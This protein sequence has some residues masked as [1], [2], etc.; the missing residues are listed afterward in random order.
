MATGFLA[1]INEEDEKNFDAK[2][3]YLGQLNFKTGS[4]N[5]CECPEYEYFPKSGVTD[6]DYCGHS[7]EDHRRDAVSPH[8]AA[9]WTAPKG[10]GKK[11]KLVKK[12][13]KSITPE[14][15]SYI[16][17][18]G[19]LRALLLDKNQLEALPSK[20]FSR[21]LWTLRELS[22]A[23]NQL[24]TIPK[25]LCHLPLLQTLTV[26]YNKLTALPSSIGK[27]ENLQYLYLNGNLLEEVP[28]E[29]SQLRK[30]KKLHLQNNR[31]RAVPVEIGSLAMLTEFLLFDNPLMQPDMSIILGGSKKIL[32]WLRE[33]E[34]LQMKQKQQQDHSESA[35]GSSGKGRSPLGGDDMHAQL[36]RL[37]LKDPRAREVFRQS[38][39]QEYAEENLEFWEAVERFRYEATL[40]SKDRA[41][42]IGKATEVYDKFFGPKSETEVNLPAQ[43]RKD[44]VAIFENENLRESVTKT[45]FNRAQRSIFDLM[46]TDSFSRH[47]KSK[48]HQDF[49]ASQPPTS[50]WR[51]K[52]FQSMPNIS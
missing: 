33:Q 40:M 5:S 41:R 13:V 18:S 49:V 47:L 44:V 21:Q 32:S 34:K 26:S 38:L 6:C 36:F 42:I 9:S 19:V 51:K 45:I 23:N 2:L 43:I 4:C 12:N 1:F 3:N 24:T 14:L 39:K 35:D 31:L 11:L 16:H 52:Q 27:L 17:D 25:E 30:L 7:V 10:K 46:K 8:P 50:V 29:I 37:V 15:I 22:L 20:L 28:K 48:A